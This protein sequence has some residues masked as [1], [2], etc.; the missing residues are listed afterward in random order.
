MER[1]TER[2]YKK[3]DGYYMK[4]SETCHIDCGEKPYCE[5]VD[6]IVD[7]LGQIEDILGHTYD[8]DRLRELIE[9]DR[10]GRCVVLKFAPG[11]TVYR[12][13]VHP[14]NGKTF[15]TE[16]HMDSVKSCIEAELWNNAYST[17]EAAK[18]AL[19]ERGK[20]G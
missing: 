20:D 2:H 6:N 1:M 11:S 17:K 15:I 4:C 16:H 12:T 10:D 5:E 18:Q 9:A 3:S 13:W 14:G 8:L 7:R 19:K